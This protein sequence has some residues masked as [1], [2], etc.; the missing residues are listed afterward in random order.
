M[1]DTERRSESHVR[2]PIAR[3][4]TSQASSRHRSGSTSRRLV[5]FGLTSI[6]GFLIG[7]VGL[8]AAIGAEGQ[9]LASDVRVIPILFPSFLLAGLGSVVLAIA[10]TESKRRS[11]SSGGRT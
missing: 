5:F 8:L 3:Q 11:R 1:Y 9:Q 6:W 7:I 10:Y 4:Y 2:P